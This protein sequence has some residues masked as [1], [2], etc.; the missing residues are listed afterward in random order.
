MLRNE[1]RLSN[2]I[3]RIAYAML[4]TRESSYAFSAS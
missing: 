4:I 3:R 1:K 2:N